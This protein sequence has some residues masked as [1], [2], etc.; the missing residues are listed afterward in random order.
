MRI[1]A[2]IAHFAADSGSGGNYE[3]RG[4]GVT[5]NNKV[6]NP[7]AGTGLNQCKRLSFIN[8]LTTQKSAH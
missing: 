4:F 6:Y 1:L 7:Y 2:G 8:G 3:Y 5:K